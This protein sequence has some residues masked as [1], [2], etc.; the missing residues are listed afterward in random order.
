MNKQSE[1]PQ[2]RTTRITESPAAKTIEEGKNGGYRPGAGR[3]QGST[4]K[5]TATMILATA[6]RELGKPLHQSIIEGYVDCI[7]DG[8]RKNRLVYENML[9][10][11]VVAHLATVEVVD[12]TDTV[13]ERQQQFKAAIA[14]ALSTTVNNGHSRVV[15]N[16]SRP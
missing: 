7:R 16:T 4:H 2:I 6:E 13:T 11:K 8:D 1:H 12:T 15:S 14:Q 9:L 10:N 3:P 5:L